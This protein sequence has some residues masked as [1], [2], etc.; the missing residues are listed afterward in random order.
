MLCILTIKKLILNSVI[1]TTQSG[2]P[3]IFL[4]L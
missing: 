2:A 3:A 4:W 1:F